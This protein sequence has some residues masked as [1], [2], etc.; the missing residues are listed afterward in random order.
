M[1]RYAED[2]SCTTRFQPGESYHK[3]EKSFRDHQTA[4]RWYQVPVINGSRQAQHRPGTLY[5]RGQGAA[6]NLVEA[7][8]GCKLAAFQKSCRG[9]RK[10]RILETKM[11]LDQIRAARWLAQ[12]Y[13]DRL[14]TIDK[15]PE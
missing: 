10:F 2:R 9:R 15:N 14:A 7:Y 8:A 11:R 13:Y 5:A 3:G 12:D 1:I 4:F 6:R